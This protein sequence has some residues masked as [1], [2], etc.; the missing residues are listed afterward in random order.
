MPEVKFEDL[1]TWLDDEV[2]EI[3]EYMKNKGSKL[4]YDSFK[5][6]NDL[7]KRSQELIDK[8]N[9]D[10]AG[11]QKSF[12]QTQAARSI[13]HLSKTILNILGEEKP[14]PEI[15]YLNIKKLYDELERILQLIY[16][17]REKW[18]REIGP[19]YILDMRR[20]GG[21]ID[22][23]SQRMREIQNFMTGEGAKLKEIE[24][25]YNK[26]QSLTGLLNELKKLEIKS[27]ET[28]RELDQANNALT[29]LQQELEMI[30]SS[31][32]L[33]ELSK[34]E[35]KI[36]ELRRKLLENLRYLE[37]PFRK[38][39]VSAQRGNLSFTPEC[40]EALDNYLK[41]PF[42]E[43]LKET[44]D[45][46]RLKMIVSNIA[47]AINEGKL[48]IKS[49]MTDKILSQIDRITNKNILAEIKRE[50]REII[51]RRNELLADGKLGNLQSQRENLIKKMEEMAR[52]KIELE[53]EVKRIK[54]TYREITERVGE[55]KRDLEE[56][57]AS[58]TLKAVKVDIGVTMLT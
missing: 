17:D 48:Q 34:I 1:K 29:N 19:Y 10:L 9:R 28:N 37:K 7:R 16:K 52:R 41:D 53:N 21:S 2:R 39:L 12:Y 31:N 51:A 20:L 13:N 18:I 4:Y 24:E 56:K 45:L 35:R 47:D 27:D 38:G 32:Y 50:C 25:I 58:L 30:N 14:L 40:R 36:E 55:Q 46:P 8:S 33:I 5:T 26:I 3:V 23:I 42:S 22:N 11:K 49:K 43:F 57:I 44:E 6:L 54:N 15:S